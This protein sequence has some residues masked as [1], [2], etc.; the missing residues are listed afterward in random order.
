MVVTF[1]IF[2]PPLYQRQ[3]ETKNNYRIS[4]QSRSDNYVLFDD[5]KPGDIVMATAYNMKHPVYV[6]EECVHKNYLIF[7]VVNNFCYLE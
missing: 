2:L 4:F 1:L 3:Q 7:R 5:A 6:E